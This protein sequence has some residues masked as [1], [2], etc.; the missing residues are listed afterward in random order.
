[1]ALAAALLLLCAALLP[2]AAPLNVALHAQASFSRSGMVVGSEVTCAG[3]KRAFEALPPSGGEGGVPYVEVFSPFNYDALTARQWDIVVIEGWFTQIHAFIHEVR[4]TSAAARPVVLYVAAAIPG[5][6]DNFT[7]EAEGMRALSA[8]E[9]DGF[10]VNSGR[11]RADLRAAGAPVAAM[12]LAVDDEIFRP[13]ATRAAYAHNVTYV[14]HSMGLKVCL[15]LPLHFKRILLTILT[16]P[17][18]ILTFK[19]SR[20]GLKLKPN[21]R[22]ML[23]AAVP[24]GVTIYGAGWGSDAELAP[25]WGG[26][27][28]PGE[29]ATLYSSANVVLGSTNEDQAEYGM[30]NN[31]AFE[32][33]ACGAALLFEHFPELEAVFGSTMRYA[34][35]GPDASAGPGASGGGI[36]ASTTA[37][38]H[39]MINVELAAARNSRRAAATALIR[40]HHTWVHRVRDIV[41]FAAELRAARPA[42]GG[43]ALRAPVM[44]VLWEGPGAGAGEGAGAG[45]AALCGKSTVQRQLCATVERVLDAVAPFYRVVRLDMNAPG[46]GVDLARL[47]YA[48][49]I[50]VVVSAIGGRPDEMVRRAVDGGGAPVGAQG[51]A[52]GGAQWT[53]RPWKRRARFAL[54]LQGAVDVA[55]LRAEP[56][57]LEVYDALLNK[58]DSQRAALLPF[59]ATLQHAYGVHCGAEARHAAAAPTARSLDSLF[60]AAGPLDALLLR[61]ARSAAR[62]RGA[63]ACSLALLS[64]AASSAASANFTRIVNAATPKMSNFVAADASGWG[65]REWCAAVASATRVVFLGSSPGGAEGAGGALNFDTKV[66]LFMYRYILCESCTHNLTRS[67]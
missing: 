23:R 27:L 29:L 3:L 22:A 64:G 52:Q 31:R 57:R 60:V 51:G 35:M 58:M 1:M 32:A 14:G 24:F 19:N 10:L 6:G 43:A 11:L 66:S 55:A 54:L 16:C 38:L 15:Y 40:G 48:F 21:L 7:S 47:L 30:V 44:G 26:V 9:V 20:S 61:R 17:P 56:R 53:P 62:K 25:H 46:G 18:H 41:A 8:L 2:L 33:V 4:R 59:H 45:G 37:Q 42:A 63:G 5:L 36:G 13:I 50:V 12:L 34:K 39:A 49:D 28:P 65:N 67:P